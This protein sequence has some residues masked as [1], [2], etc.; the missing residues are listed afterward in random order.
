[1]A[2]HNLPIAALCAKVFVTTSFHTNGSCGLFK[3][4]DVVQHA[5]HG[6]GTIEGE[7]GIWREKDATGGQDLDINGRGIYEIRFEGESEVRSI[8]GAG[9]SLVEPAPGAH[10]AAEKFPKLAPAD[11]A[12]LKES[13]RRNGQFEPIALDASGQILDGRHRW[14]ICQELGITPR[15]IQFSE[16]SAKSPDTLS[17][18]RFILDN[19]LQRRHL[20]ATQRATLALEFLPFLRQEAKARIRA[21][22][23]RARRLRIEKLH[24]GGNGSSN[25]KEPATAP[26]RTR[27]VLAERS[28]V[29][30][31][32]VDRVLA[33]R[34]HAP[35]LLPAMANGELAATRAMKLV[36][37]KVNGADQSAHRF[38][39]DKAVP[40]SKD[41]VLRQWQKVWSSFVLRFPPRERKKK[42]SSSAGRPAS[43]KWRS[44]FWTRRM[45]LEE[46][47]K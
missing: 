25:G 6:R 40:F 2:F 20:T 36:H 9:L 33:V 11:Y 10:P 17:E 42:H 12:A 41:I 23:D 38:C 26:L 34:R 4:G 35:E 14:Q 1:M 22:A 45:R 8:N 28:G 5:V 46:S 18:E 13:I 47:R 39:A 27:D 19:N 15:T 44:D 24:G 21:G 32:T 29:A 16:L 37:A 43:L 31:I 7:W 30:P 3:R